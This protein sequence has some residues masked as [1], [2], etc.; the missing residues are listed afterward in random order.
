MLDER[1]RSA[2][3]ER[4]VLPVSRVRGWLKPGVDLMRF[5]DYQATEDLEYIERLRKLK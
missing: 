5:S 2:N 3:R 4:I 1:P